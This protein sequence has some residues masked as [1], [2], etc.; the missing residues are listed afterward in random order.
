MNMLNV[1][2]VNDKKNSTRVTK[3]GHKKP[4]INKF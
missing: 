4:E 2:K 3:K 1:F